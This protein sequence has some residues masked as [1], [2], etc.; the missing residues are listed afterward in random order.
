[1]GEI[2]DEIKELLK[3]KKFNS[4]EEMNKFVQEHADQKNSTPLEDFGG[5]SP[6]QMSKLL[7][8][9]F[10]SNDSPVVFNCNLS[11]DELKNALFYCEARKF[12]NLIKDNSPIPATISGNLNRNFVSSAMNITKYETS[13][14]R[15]YC[16][17]INEQDFFWLHITR[18][19]FK[20]ADL[21]RVSN[22]EIYDYKKGKRYTE[23]G[24]R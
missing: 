21:I 6:A 2:I 17:V 1:M 9:P 24:A 19:I 23:C 13:S 10:D 18:L 20:F 5:L 11:E 16:K 4:I 3:I 12:L 22:Q 15:E 8:I 14:I 7:Y